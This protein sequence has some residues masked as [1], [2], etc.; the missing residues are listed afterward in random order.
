MLL[1]LI[2]LYPIKQTCETL[3]KIQEDPQKVNEDVSHWCTYWL[4]YAF[5]MQY[6]F[7]LSYI[8]FWSMLSP[9]VLIMAYTPVYTKMIYDGAITT[10]RYKILLLNK[11]LNLQ[12]HLD[13]VAQKY[14]IPGLDFMEENV[15]KNLP[16]PFSNIL[17]QFSQIVHSV[18]IYQNRT[19]QHVGPY[20]VSELNVTKTD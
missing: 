20:K 9:F 12:K 18:L 13:S 10:L 17:I 16:S 3:K 2:S 7:I 4:I 5:L 19:H 14:L 11:T 8:P 15:G 1:W 6:D